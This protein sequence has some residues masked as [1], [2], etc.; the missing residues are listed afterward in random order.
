MIP[1]VRFVTAPREEALNPAPWFFEPA[2]GGTDLVDAFVGVA[3]GFEHDRAL[4][5]LLPQALAQVRKVKAARAG[6]GGE[7]PPAVPGKVAGVQVAEPAAHGVE[8][9][10]G[11]A[12]AA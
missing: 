11:V 8:D 1:C 2:Q 3:V 5:A 10:V 12:A 7:H 9:V 4:V 6:H